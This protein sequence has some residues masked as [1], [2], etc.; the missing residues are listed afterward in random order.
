VEK[1]WPSLSRCFNVAP[2]KTTRYTLSAEGGDHKVVTE[3]L[4]VVVQH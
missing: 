3:S 2:T 1:V 4:D